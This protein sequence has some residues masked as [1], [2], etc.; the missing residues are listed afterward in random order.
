MAIRLAWMTD[1]LFGLRIGN[2]GAGVHLRTGACHSQ[3]TAYRQSLTIRLFKADIILL[4]G[5]FPAVHGNGDR[6]GVIADRAAA[7]SQQKIRM[8]VPCDLD[9]LIELINGRVGHNA[10]DLCHILSI[11]IQNPNDI[12]IDSV[13]LN[14]TAAVD[15]HD[16]LAVL[17]QLRVQVVQSILA[18][19]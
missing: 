6:L 18:E 17:R 11:L 4:P 8:V 10:G 13:L 14:G 5:I 9:A 2:H 15:Q 7:H 12:I 19:I 3:H 16:I 1:L